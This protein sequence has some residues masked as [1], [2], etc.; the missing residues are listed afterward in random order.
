MTPEELRSFLTQRQARF[1]ERQIDHGIQFRCSP[2][3]EVFNVYNTGKLQI[4]GKRGTP[5]SSAVD[6]W[7]STQSGQPN[8]APA[9]QSQPSAGIDRRVFVVYGHDEAAHTQLELL[10]RRMGLDPILLQ[11]LPA[12]G[13]T[14]IEKLDR[15]F[16]Q[17]GHV[18]FACVLLTP[19]DE[20]YAVGRETE[21]KYRAR[22]NVILELGMALA[23]LGR[24]RVAIL[25]KQSVER[26]SDIAGLIYIPF[27]ER[28]D[29]V[30]NKL[31]QELKTA[32]YDPRLEG[33]T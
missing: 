19:D 18:G 23:R 24:R 3:G 22:Q 2:G 1:E 25:H 14:L 17:D 7:L 5:L 11:Q 27:T 28:V 33:L 29:E 12:E 31:F 4:A 10:L 13:E 20:G 30:K 16:A 9:D 15:Y 6:S 8:A 21:K 32:G 26:P